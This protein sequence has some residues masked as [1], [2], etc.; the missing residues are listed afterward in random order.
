MNGGI[1]IMPKEYMRG[2]L[3]GFFAVGIFVIV[4][5][6][7]NKGNCER[8]YDER[9]KLI[10]GNVSMHAYLTL[11]VYCLAVGLVYMYIQRVWAD[12]YTIL[13]IGVFLSATVFVVECV[14]TDAYFAVGEKPRPWLV[15]S[16]FIA[17]M[18]LW[19]LADNLAEG[20]RLI[21]DGMLTQHVINLVSGVMFLTIFVSIIVK[22]LRDRA[23]ERS[24][25]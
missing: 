2:F 13:M 5:F 19:V 20:K 6:V 9:Q 25:R 17:A 16:G 10:R 3:V 22:L 8:K 4:A 7:L 18:N 14:F 21:A 1:Q 12:I 15:L 23:G 24:E 11:L